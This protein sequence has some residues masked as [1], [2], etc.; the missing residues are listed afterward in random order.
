MPKPKNTRHAYKPVT[1][2]D[3]LLDLIAAADAATP[4][5]AKITLSGG[6][7]LNLRR[8]GSIYRLIIWRNGIY[9]SFKEWNTICAKWPYNTGW[10][11][12]HEG[13][14]KGRKYLQGI[15]PAHPKTS[16][17]EAANGQSS[18]RTDTAADF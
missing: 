11:N 9:P 8:D 13:S 10:P 5:Q 1:L 2:E 12:P 6:L 16:E 15:I 7:N 18:G 3:A 17:M 4:N 14:F